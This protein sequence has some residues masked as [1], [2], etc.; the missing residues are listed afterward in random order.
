[1]LEEVFDMQS[2]C[3]R[4]DKSLPIIFE[5]NLSHSNAFVS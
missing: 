3:S 2:W 4:S 1:M 5:E